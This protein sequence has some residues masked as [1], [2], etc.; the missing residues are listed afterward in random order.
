VARAVLALA[1]LAF[2]AAGCGGGGS[3]SQTKLTPSA[4]V[5][6]SAKKSAQA[7]SQHIQLNGNTTVQGQTVAMKGSGD[8]DNTAKTGAMT[9]KALVG[10]LS[11]Q[12]DEVVDGT[13]IYMKSPLFAANLPAGKTWIR[14]DL[15]QAAAQ[16]G[17]DLGGLLSQKPSDSLAQ[18]QALGK[19]TEVGEEEIGG[20]KTTHYRATIDRTKLPKQLAKLNAT[21]GTYHVW[22][23]NDDQYVRRLKMSYSVQQQSIA[24][25]MNFSD[26]GK[27]VSVDVPT[28]DES[29]D[30]MTLKGLGG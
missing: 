20:A 23:G 15:Q 24:M 19:V 16:Q 21:F 27:D 29:V 5:M 3:S 17:L 9:L 7:T 18:L 26:F 11:M 14:L 4:Y 6:Q 12:I 10:G 1:A 2:V 13:V 8:F 28:A 30:A 25:T 22:I